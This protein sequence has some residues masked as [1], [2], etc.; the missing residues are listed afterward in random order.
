MQGII[1][2]K[3]ERQR[4]RAPKKPGALGAPDD[5][6]INLALTTDCSALDLSRNERGE[7]DDVVFA[8]VSELLTGSKG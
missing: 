6:P 4:L 5:K 1:Y 7:S 8:V 3:Q 2:C